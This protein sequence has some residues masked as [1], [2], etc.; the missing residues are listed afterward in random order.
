[1]S[2]F[3]GRWADEQVDVQLVAALRVHVAR[4]AGQEARD[5]AG[6]QAT[7]NHGLRL[8]WPFDSSGF[9]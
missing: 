2:I 4:N 3:I 5:V 7:P 1:L 6:Q 8:C 9:G